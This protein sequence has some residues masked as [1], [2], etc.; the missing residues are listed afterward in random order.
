MSTI[1]V[2]D[3]VKERL[4]DLKRDDESFNDLLDRLS[5]SEKDVEE[6]AQ[7]LGAINDGTLGERME[8]ANDELN[9]SLERRTE[10]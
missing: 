1:R 8:E 9:E 3:D 4:R 2:S 5:R 7:S 6:I 10:K